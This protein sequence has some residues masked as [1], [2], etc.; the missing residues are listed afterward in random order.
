LD[1][2]LGWGLDN[3][4]DLVEEVGNLSV[5]LFWALNFIFF[6]LAGSSTMFF[7]LTVV[8]RSLAVYPF[9]WLAALLPTLLRIGVLGVS[10]ILRV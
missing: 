1:S 7:A 2:K 3:I 6:L 10:F 5:C 4:V 9:G 8:G